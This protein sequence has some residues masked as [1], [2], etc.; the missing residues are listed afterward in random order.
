MNR[1]KG[2]G[3]GMG[4]QTNSAGWISTGR[5][6]G[7]TLTS[8]CCCSSSCWGRW[9][10]IRDWPVQSKTLLSGRLATLNPVATGATGRPAR[11]RAN[12]C[13]TPAL[14]WRAERSWCS[15]QCGCRLQDKWKRRNRQNDYHHKKKERNAVRFHQSGS[16][17]ESAAHDNNKR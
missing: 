3:I 11:R 15:G 5:R 6:R 12:P 17:I 2:R 10:G 8:F 14:G 7:V 13:C 16:G 1:R 4:R 9:L